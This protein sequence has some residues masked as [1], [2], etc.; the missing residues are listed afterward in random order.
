MKTHYQLS[1]RAYKRGLDVKKITEEGTFDTISYRVPI[2]G[3]GNTISNKGCEAFESRRSISEGV[4]EAL[5]DENISTIGDYGMGGMGKTML[6]KEVAKQALED[7]LFD[8]V[9]T[10][11][12]SR[13]PD[14]KKIQKYIAEKLGLTL[15]EE[16][17]SLRAYWLHERLKKEEDPY[18]CR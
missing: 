3:T 1:K 16:N 2:Q 17:E 13:T 4:M 8:E 18:K 6:V 10:V 15:H 14:L 9:V 7:K 11:V 12:V 5:K